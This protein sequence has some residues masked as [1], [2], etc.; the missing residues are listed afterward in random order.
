MSVGNGILR[1]PIFGSSFEGVIRD[2]AGRIDI[3]G[4]FMPAYGINRLFGSI[5]IVGQI[6]GNGNEGGLLGITYRLS[7]AFA[8]PSLTVNP[9]SIVAPGIFRQIFEY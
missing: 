1:G 3:A 8:S 5:P 6:L 4:S 9:L 7:G 2:A